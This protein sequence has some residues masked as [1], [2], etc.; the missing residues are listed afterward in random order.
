MSEVTIKTA[1]ESEFFRRGKRLS[2]LADAGQPLPAQ[3][4]VS[5]EDPA[6][7]LS[8]LTPAKLEL[9]RSVKKAPASITIIAAR[10][11]RD[12]SAVKRDVDQLESAGLVIVETK[13]LPGHGR[14]KEVRPV[15][16]SFRLEALV[17]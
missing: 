2:K 3:H 16:R 15:A 8:L 4:V 14:M 12:R 7:M 6:D 11:Q 5:F 17:A 1:G 13:T 10:L 9:L